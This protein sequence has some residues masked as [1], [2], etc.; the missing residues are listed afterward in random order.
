[1]S[2][3]FA[4]WPVA[5]W[6]AE[7]IVWASA[8]MLVVLMLRR[9][10]AS[11]FGAGAA[12]ALWLVPAL[13][14][15]APPGDWLANLF[16]FDSPLPPMIV[17]IEMLGAGAPLPP[18]G[19]AGQWLPT[20]LAVWAGGAFLFLVYQGW[21]Y[22][23]FVSRI[24]RSQRDAGRHHGVA[25]VASAAAD[26]PLAIGL[27][28][29]RIVVP[30]DFS[31]RYSPAE[32]ALALAH[33][34]HH[35]RRGDLVA[36][37]VALIMLALNWFNPI[38]WIAFRAFRA[39]Q[40]LSC[41]AAVAAAADPSGRADYGRALVKSASRP[42][43]IA[44]CPLHSAHQ[45]KRRLK[46]LSHHRPDRRRRLG[47]AAVTAG[48]I[49]GSLMLGSPGLAAD[50]GP[51]EAVVAAD[52]EPAAH[53]SEAAPAIETRRVRHVVTAPDKQP[54]SGTATPER[55]ERRERV[56]I[57]ERRD[58]GEGRA[59]GET[60]HRE[61]IRRDLSPEAAARVEACRSENRA[62]NVEEDTDNRRTRIMIC[63]DGASGENQ[64]A[65]LQRA[66]ERIASENDLSA[67]T[68]A[69]VLAQ[70]DQAIARARQ[71]R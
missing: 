68:K 4:D 5:A 45:L 2:V 50:A 33:E 54:R 48:L 23:A 58:S 49:A 20:I 11:L 10:V 28:R 7:N 44:A 38:A 69:R 18:D 67:E 31:D 32:Q 17:E 46:M 6:L 41:D 19:G 47:G 30:L 43:L 35:H 59:E 21:T 9:P 25:V 62:V 3:A 70:L 64:V 71:G 29:R 55:E 34:A 8:A 51:A 57:M 14:L 56:I 53:A 66:R 13:R 52:A 39:D 16:P 27:L 42:G 63:A 15:V 60:R 1:M 61:I 40:E 26:G 36:N 65:A 12:Y 22:R 37:H 24:E